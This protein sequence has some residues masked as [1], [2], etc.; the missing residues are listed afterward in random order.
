MP[1]LTGF[2]VAMYRPNDAALQ[3][4]RDLVAGY[5]GSY[6]YFAVTP[7]NF[8][9]LTD[10]E[11]VS[12]VSGTFTCDSC[13]VHD[14]S[15]PTSPAVLAQSVKLLDDQ[16]T[17]V[18]QGSISDVYSVS[19][20]TR[21]ETNVSITNNHNYLTYGSFENLPRLQSGGVMYAYAGL[22][23]G[24]TVCVFCLVDIIFRRI[25]GRSR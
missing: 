8:Y 9:L 22:F 5:R 10:C 25:D 13:T 2:D 24:V 17:Q 19:L 14:I 3:V 15:L 7:T 21:S 16:G 18:Y 6:Y 1:S 4:A 11:N 23:L 12:F 20:S